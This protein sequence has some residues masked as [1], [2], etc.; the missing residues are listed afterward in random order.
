M[1]LKQR[2]FQLISEVMAYFGDN[3]AERDWDQFMNLK[4]AE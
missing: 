2:Y 4:R 3:F 1:S